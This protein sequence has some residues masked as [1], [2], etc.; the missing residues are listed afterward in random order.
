M[1]VEEL[2]LHSYTVL[3]S[4]KRKEWKEEQTRRENEAGQ[5]SSPGLPRPQISYCQAPTSSTPPSGSF[6]VQIIFPD[7]CLASPSLTVAETCY[8]TD[9]HCSG[10]GEPR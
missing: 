7:Q 10:A 9:E 1:C 4:R 3:G 6:E 5:W 2:K 8:F